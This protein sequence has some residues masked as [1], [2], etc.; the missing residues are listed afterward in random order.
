MGVVGTMV[1][2]EVKMRQVNERSKCPYCSGSGQLTCA[3]CYGQQTV[4]YRTADGQVSACVGGVGGVQAGRRAG[5]LTARHGPTTQPPTDTNQQ[6]EQHPCPSCM[7]AGTVTC[8]NC[9]GDG[10]AI[11]VML[12]KKVSRDPETRLEEYGMG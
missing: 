8:I 6:I 10:L 7:G 4:S 2:L 9:K 3:R 12:D 1:A 5:P 11:P